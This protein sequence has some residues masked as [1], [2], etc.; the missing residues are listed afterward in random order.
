MILPE[1]TGKP[2]FEKK[3]NRMS[4]Y[5]LKEN[6]KYVDKLY[7]RQRPHACKTTHLKT[8]FQIEK[9]YSTGTYCQ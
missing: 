8:K 2:D 3:M 7:A 5:R 1:K 6:V 9:T 4:K